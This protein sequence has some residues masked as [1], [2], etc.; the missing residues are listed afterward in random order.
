MIKKRSRWSWGEAVAGFVILSVRSKSTKW[1]SVFFCQHLRL[2]SCVKN[3]FPVVEQ[4]YRSSRW[5][6][7][8]WRLAELDPTHLWWRSFHASVHVFGVM[9]FLRS[10]LIKMYG[11]KI[12]MECRFGLWSLCLLFNACSSDNSTFFRNSLIRLREPHL[13][14]YWIAF[15]HCL[16]KLTQCSSPHY[17]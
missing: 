17:G 2:R 10:S 14:I 4:I 3:H 7:T 8:S 16:C 6:V 1:P 13:L 5:P 12:L 15:Q 11:E 9:G